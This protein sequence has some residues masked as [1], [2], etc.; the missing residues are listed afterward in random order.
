MRVPL[1]TANWKMNKTIGD[2]LAFAGEFL[3]LMLDI[4]GHKRGAAGEAGREAAAWP[5][6]A[7]CPPFTAIPALSAVL[8]G[9]PVSVGAQDVFWEEKGAF[10]GEVSAAMLK[11]AGCLYVIAGHSERRHILG[12]MDPMVQKKVRA[13]LDHGM[14]PILC[15]GE[16]IEEREKGQTYQVCETMTREGLAKV[17]PEEIPS[18]VIAYEPVWAIGTGREAKPDDAADVIR[19]VRSTDRKSVV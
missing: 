16:T 12:E 18:V 9:H 14:R 17:K 8:A 2:T 11:D 10:T 5:E 19:H 1:L 3:P 13:I 15:V 7:I 6:V 4:M